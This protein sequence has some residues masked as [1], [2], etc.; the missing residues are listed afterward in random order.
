MTERPAIVRLQDRGEA[1]RRYSG[2]LLWQAEG[3]PGLA[4]KGLMTERPAIVG[5]QD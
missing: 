2:R 5:L 1:R 3:Q 4:V